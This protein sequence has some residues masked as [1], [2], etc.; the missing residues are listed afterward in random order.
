[1]SNFHKI[2]HL[3]QV[4]IVDGMGLPESFPVSALDNIRSARSLYPSAQYKMWSGNDVRALIYDNFHPEV[5][6]A[7]DGIRPYAYK[8]DLA[9]YC[10]LYV[11]GGIYFDLGIKLLDAWNI[12]VDFGVASFTE[13]YPGMDSWTNN[14]SSLLWSLPGRDEWKYCID[15]IVK[16]CR[17]FYYGPHDHYPTG[18]VV[19]G[20]SLASKFASDDFSSM[21]DDQF[22]GEVRYITPESYPQ[23]CTFV[24]PNKQV[25]GIRN[26]LTAGDMGGFIAS[27]S[28][29][30]VEMFKSRHVYDGQ[31]ERV[32]SL[33]DNRFTMDRASF[34]THSGARVLEG[35]SGRVMYGPYI[36]LEAGSYRVVFKFSDDTFFSR[37]FIDIVS[38]PNCSLVAEVSLSNEGIK[39]V[40]EVVSH[41]SS[42]VDLR[43]VEFRMSVFSDFSGELQSISLIK[44]A[45]HSIHAQVAGA[46]SFIH[47]DTDAP[48]QFG[49]FDEGIRFANRVVGGVA[50]I[51]GVKGIC[52]FGPYIN[53]VRGHYKLIVDLSK[54][55]CALGVVVEVCANGGKDVLLSTALGA[56]SSG[57]TVKTF[58]F[59]V[60]H[61]VRD[62]EFRVRSTR[63]FSAIF[64]RFIL[65][66]SH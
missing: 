9:R 15:T 64:N 16:N 41:F 17:Q 6:E 49:P 18:P 53:L 14:Q 3:H 39:R 25:V 58:E 47:S 36:D 10:I 66:K 65:S 21:I 43:D 29:S 27:G 12:P 62:V 20:R 7:F 23:H 24:G 35:A 46:Q 57:D 33:I 28:N 4:S 52:V 22:I 59:N 2:T 13:M 34:R 8:C 61:E 30:Y 11:H 1:M 48:R 45:S 5:L 51:G 54:V 63:L 50:K 38:S 19:L 56:F 32:W 31:V 60:T 37:I 40:T 55:F 42:D 44:D 26:K